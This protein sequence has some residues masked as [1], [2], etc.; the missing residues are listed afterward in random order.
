MTFLLAL[1]VAAQPATIPPLRLGT[2]AHYVEGGFVT[3]LRLGVLD[4]LDGKS[5][6]GLELRRVRFSLRGSLFDGQLGFGVQLNT[7]PAALE[8]LDAWAQWVPLKGMQ[9]RAGQF[10]TPFT[11][12][13]QQS[14]RSLSLADWSL[15]AVHFG[16]ERQLGLAWQASGGTATR[17]DAAFGLFSGQNARA[18][19]ARGLADAYS[20]TLDNPSDLRVAHGPVSLHPE[21]V[22][23]FGLE[24]SE[25]RSDVSSDEQGGPLRVSAAFSAAWDLKPTKNVDFQARLAPEVL[26]KWEHWSLE[27]V[28]YGGWAPIAHPTSSP[29]ETLSASGAVAP[30]SLGA[31]AE[32][33]RWVHPRVLLAGRFSRVELLPELRRDVQATTGQ[34]ISSAKQEVALAATVR[35]VGSLL[36]AQFETGWLHERTDQLRVRLQLQLAL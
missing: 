13:R 30:V 18:A 14:F 15:A 33:S 6:V 10:K 3:Q 5:N 7:T 29:Q 32:L 2:D 1:V 8:L 31:T 21:L 17:W 26:L 25:T 35:I 9:F 20:V 19:F 22:V 24:S 12:H 27:V 23:R 36:Q 11:K 4:T 34:V 16:A 28:G